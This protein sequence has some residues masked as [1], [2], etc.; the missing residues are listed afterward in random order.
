M[1]TFFMSSIALTLMPYLHKSTYEVACPFKQKVAGVP[2]VS[3]VG[4][5]SAA[6]VVLYEYL[7][8]ANPVYF[9]ITPIALEA[10]GATI[11][12]FLVLYVVVR[13]YRKSHGIDLDIIYR[14]IPPE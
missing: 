1:L 6:L 2:A 13:A 9:G 10:M 4:I 14:E 3:I 5:L 8:I 7:E 12:F 11:V